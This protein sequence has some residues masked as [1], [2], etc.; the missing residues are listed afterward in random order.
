MPFG[1]EE[2]RN[3]R[4]RAGYFC[5]ICGE[6]HPPIRNGETGLD[7]HS[8]DRTHTDQGLAVCTGRKGG[9]NCHNKLHAV[10]NDPEELRK[11]S[12]EANSLASLS[13]ADGLLKKNIPEN[14]IRRILGRI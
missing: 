6:W 11:I 8:L 12:M 1:P 9:D 7:A 2:R 5:Q 10:T 3:I 4:E 14:K 13:M